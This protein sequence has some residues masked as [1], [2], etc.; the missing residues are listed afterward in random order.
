MSYV[1]GA[2]RYLGQVGNESGRILDSSPIPSAVKYHHGL[3]REL[4]D[5]GILRD[6][7][8]PSLQVHGSLA[9]LAYGVARATDS[10]EGKDFLWPVA[11][12]V[13]GWWSAVGRKG[14]TLPQ[15]FATLSRPE[16][17]LLAGVTLW[18]GRLFYRIASRSARRRKG[19]ARLRRRALRGGQEGA[20]VLEQGALYPAL[21][22]TVISL[23]FTAPFHHQGAVLTGYHPVIQ[24]VAVGLF[25]AGFALEVLADKQLEGFKQDDKNKNAVCKEGVWSLVR[26]PNYL[27]DSL[28]HFSF[29]LLLYGSDMLAPIEIL[30]CLANYAFLR[31]IGGDK[32]TEQ[33]QERR[34]SQTNLEKHADFKKFKETHNS[35]WPRVEVVKNKWLWYVLGAGV[36]GAAVEQAV[37]QLF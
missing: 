10:V 14:L 24:A 13:N 20:R 22:Q 37:H 35:V 18:G 25:S 26:H 16:R 1:D 17:L 32:Q 4:L 30:G 9:L 12:M 2:G 31:Y 36:V 19:G 33:H 15:A 11:P 21:I 28:V 34:Y 7:I 5:V 6:T 27:G 8:L 29:P 3:R 23:P